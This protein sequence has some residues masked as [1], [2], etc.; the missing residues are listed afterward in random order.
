MCLLICVCFFRFLEQNIKNHFFA[1]IE[2]YTNLIENAF[3][4]TKIK[5]GD[6]LHSNLY[7]VVSRYHNITLVSISISIGL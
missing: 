1:I 7:D 4:M 6:L 2:N 5:I 3:L